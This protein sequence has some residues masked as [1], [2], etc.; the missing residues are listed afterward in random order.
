VEASPKSFPLSKILMEKA[1]AIFNTAYHHALSAY[2]LK[3]ILHVYIE[4]NLFALN[5]I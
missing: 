1:E 2:F 3:I 5:E 4:K